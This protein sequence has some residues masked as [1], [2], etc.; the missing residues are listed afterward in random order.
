MRSTGP[1]NPEM[2]V[3]WR[4]SNR[5][6]SVSFAGYR[7]RCASAPAARAPKRGLPSP[8]RYARWRPAPSRRRRFSNTERANRH[9]R[10][11]SVLGRHGTSSLSI[12]HPAS[13]VSSNETCDVGDLAALTWDDNPKLERVAEESSELQLE[14]KDWLR[15]QLK[16][17]ARAS[18]DGDYSL[19]T[20]ESRIELPP[21]VWRCDA[22]DDECGRVVR[23]GAHDVELVLAATLLGDC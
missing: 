17:P 20:S 4:D 1:T 14:S 5:A 21:D 3:E 10:R 16:R 22:S 19:R 11:R 9:R 2:L 15:A 23:F 12:S 6:E 7:S 18:A 8:K 13:L